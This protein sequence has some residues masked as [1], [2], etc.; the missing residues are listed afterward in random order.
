MPDVNDQL[1][2][3]RRQLE[4][5][6][7]RLEI[8]ELGKLL[9]S[10]FSTDTDWT[11]VPTNFA[12]YQTRPHAGPRFM[13]RYQ[14][15]IWDRAEGRWGPF[16]ETEQDLSIH[17]AQARNLATF[18]AISIG[19]IE[20]LADY[21]IGRDWTYTVVPKEMANRPDF[22]VPED[23]IAECQRV[24]DDTLEA[25]DWM[26]D[27]DRE[28]H[29]SA[30]ETGDVP[31]LVF[32]MRNGVCRFDP[33]DPEMVAEPSQPKMLEE[34]LDVPESQWNFGVHALPMGRDRFDYGRPA[35][36]HVIYD[37]SGANWEYF[38]RLP[39][40][41]FDDGSGRFCHH[42]KRNTGRVAARGIS[43]F[44]PI[45]EDLE[46]EYKL[47]KN[48]RV[49]ASVQAAIAYIV[50]HSEGAT[51][52]D[53]DT[54]LSSNAVWLIDRATQGG[55]S[56]TANVSSMKPGTRVDIG[57]GTNYH[58]GPLGALRS[59]VFVDIAAFILRRIGV[60]WRMPEYMISGDASN[61]NFASTLV[62]ESPFVKA[63]ESD[64][65]YFANQYRRMLMKCLRVAWIHGC[66]SRWSND[67]TD[68]SRA[69]DISIQT[70]SPASRN[71]LE[72]SQVNQIEFA[73]GIIDEKQWATDAG[74]D[75]DTVQ[76][77]R[78]PSQD[79]SFSGQSGA[80]AQLGQAIES[81]GGLAHAREIMDG[82]YTTI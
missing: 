67:W 21:T 39:D 45:M 59:P 22:S 73:H 77:A 23:M 82:V 64:Q 79:P 29:N 47:A 49:G 76:P 74:R 57:K 63:R 20:S 34:W 78:M 9:E 11:D 75:P 55:G 53:V 35:G 30:R 13:R 61:G 12:Q 31:I 28:I 46:G 10:G 8:K 27:L 32:P 36:Y 37:D 38:P 6:A 3:A 1:E 2:E 18:T 42:I 33:I 48:T 16:Y 66:F 80:L 65:D 81:V 44:W 15:R 50:E 26:N 7:K 41:Q 17:R 24:I 62:A 5:T 52:S 70:P 69:I 25:N 71:K 51:K 40:P 58:A 68:I 14:S 4:L 19:A 56:R 72:L 43:D 60:R 54:N